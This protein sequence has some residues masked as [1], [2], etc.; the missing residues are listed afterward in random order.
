VRTRYPGR[1]IGGA[2]VGWQSDSHDTLNHAA[3]DAAHDLAN[4]EL[5]WT[6]KGVRGHEEIRRSRTGAYTSRQ[7]KS[8]CMT[9]AKPAE[10]ISSFNSLARL[11]HAIQVRAQRDDN[12]PSVITSFGTIFVRRLHSIWKRLVSSERIDKVGYPRCA[13]YTNFFV[14]SVPNRYG[15]APPSYDYGL[16]G[17]NWP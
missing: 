2:P 3:A 8:R 15:L 1:S 9:R 10:V 13:R 14:R 11:Q 4:S 7:V 6:C 16:A 12:N 17:T 5:R